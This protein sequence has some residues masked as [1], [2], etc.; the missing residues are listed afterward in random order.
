MQETSSTGHQNTHVIVRR[1]GP[2]DKVLVRS[3]LERFDGV[4][5]ADPDEF[6]RDPRTLAFVAE[7]G[8]EV[9]GWLYSYELP[10]PDGSREVLLYS[11][12]V[13]EQSRRRGYGRKLI[14]ALLSEAKLQGDTELW[15]LTDNDNSGAQGL[16][17]NTGGGTGRKQIMYTWDIS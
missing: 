15:T 17:K 6:L 16:Y 1:L 14:D 10:R 11:I 9:L 5:D 12:D 3:V 13:A 2:D 7:Q 8:G 4:H